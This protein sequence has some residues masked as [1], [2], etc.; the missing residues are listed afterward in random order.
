[1]FHVIKHNISGNYLCGVDSEGLPVFSE[2]YDEALWS[3][4]ESAITSVITNNSLSDVSTT[5]IEGGGGNNP[6]RR[7]GF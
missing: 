3:R 6:P 4:H 5:T 7:P 1:M 2:N